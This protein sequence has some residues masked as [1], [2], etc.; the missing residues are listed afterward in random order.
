MREL[1]RTSESECPATLVLRDETG[2]RY[3][4][5]AL[6]GRAHSSDQNAKAAEEEQ[7]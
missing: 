7:T 3:T 5:R 6:Q 4:S 2:R 1:H